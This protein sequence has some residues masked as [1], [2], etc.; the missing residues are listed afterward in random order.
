MTVYPTQQTLTARFAPP[1]LIG[2][3]F[4]FSAISLGVGGAV[5]SVLGGALVDTGAQLGVP[6]LPWFTL[7]AI[8]VFT[9]LGLR[10]A[11]RGLD[12]APTDAT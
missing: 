1:A 11:L 5:G 3:Y 12:E 4:G 6:A 8:G 10:W 2:S 9:A 7:A